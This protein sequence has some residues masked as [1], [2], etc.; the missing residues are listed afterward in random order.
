MDRIRER[1]RNPIPAIAK[2]QSH[3]GP[4]ALIEI[5]AMALVGL[6]RTVHPVGVELTGT[7]P[8]KPDVPHV[9]RSV[10][11]GIEINYLGRRCVC[12]MIKQLQPNMARV[13]T[14]QG[15]INACFGFMWSQGQRNSLPHLSAF[16][17]LCYIIL[18]RGFRGTGLCDGPA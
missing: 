10:T 1:G 11:R 18:Q 2:S 3:K 12:G 7:N 17:N 6:V 5:E 16:R 15:K 9:T 14:E 13:T 4:E 8:L